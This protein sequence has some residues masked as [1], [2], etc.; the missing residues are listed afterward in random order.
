MTDFTEQLHN[1][2]LENATIINRDLNPLIVKKNA[3]LKR[4][5]NTKSQITT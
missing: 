2:S 3:E 4:N 5:V 1:N